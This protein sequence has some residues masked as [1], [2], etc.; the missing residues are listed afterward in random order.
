M[1]ILCDAVGGKV[2]KALV[3]SLKV[4]TN[5]VMC[6]PCTC[7]VL[8]LRIESGQTVQQTAAGERGCFVCRRCT[9]MCLCVEMF[10]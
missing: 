2:Q 10:H 8:T 3:L 1:E 7:L 5:P 4:G 9:N 6:T